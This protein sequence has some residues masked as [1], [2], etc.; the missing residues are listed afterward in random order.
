V[1]YEVSIFQN[2]VTLVAMNQFAFNLHMYTFSYYTVKW[3]I[4]CV[5]N[6][7]VKS[8]SIALNE[9]SW[10]VLRMT[11]VFP[12]LDVGSSICLEGLRTPC[13]SKDNRYLIRN[14]PS[15]KQEY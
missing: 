13:K 12:S 10:S 4:K 2:S 5:L 14:P 6:A 3:M 15:I 1:W 8:D 7:P 9:N 11:Q